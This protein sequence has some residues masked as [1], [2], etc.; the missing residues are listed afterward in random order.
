MKKRCAHRV[1][2]CTYVV[3]VV[4]AGSTRS[5]RCSRLKLELES[6]K[7][8]P[9]SVRALI[10]PR[11]GAAVAGRVG[12]RAH[13]HPNLDKKVD[14]RMSVAETR[15]ERMVAFATKIADEARGAAEQA[16]AMKGTLDS[17]VQCSAQFIAAAA[18]PASSP[19]DE[20]V[21]A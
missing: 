8:P 2:A 21:V 9:E 11:T 20:E 3:V 4:L 14:E 5:S 17:G 10:H 12:S 15:V 18:G 19:G 7:S 16:K 13:P 1:H 6:F